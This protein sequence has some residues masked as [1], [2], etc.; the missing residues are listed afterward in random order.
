M[1]TPDIKGFFSPENRLIVFL[2]CLSLYGSWDNNQTLSAMKGEIS[3]LAYQVAEL[4]KLAN[5]KQLVKVTDNQHV[6][7]CTGRSKQQNRGFPITACFRDNRNSKN[8][9]KLFT[10]T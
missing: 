1:A 10:I 8:K 2:I 6:F 7:K 9:F 4:N 3:L 5:D